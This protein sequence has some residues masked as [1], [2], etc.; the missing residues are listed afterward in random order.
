MTVHG[1]DEV[2]VIA[3]TEFSRLTG[4]RSGAALVEAMRASPY[5]EIDLE[6]ARFPMPVRDVEL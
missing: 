3:V 4:E 2:V 1:R 6:P 5:L